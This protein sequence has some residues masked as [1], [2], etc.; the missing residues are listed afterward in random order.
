MILRIYTFLI[1][2]FKKNDF[3]MKEFNIIGNFFMKSKFRQ[4]LDM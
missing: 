2:I 1:G 3:G 4:S